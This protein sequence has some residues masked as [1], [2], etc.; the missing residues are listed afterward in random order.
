[1]RNPSLLQHSSLHHPRFDSGKPITEAPTGWNSSQRVRPGVQRL[2]D[3]FRQRGY[4]CAPLDPLGHAPV[5]DEVLL[6]PQRFGLSPTEAVTEDG[7][8]LLGVKTV[9]E[10]TTTLRAIYCGNLT[11][12]ASAVRD[13]ARLAWLHAEMEAPVSVD[14]LPAAMTGTGL[15][16]RLVHVQTWEH[17]VARRFPHAKRFSL[18]GCEA[19][20]PLL[21]VLV[22]QAGAHGVSKLVLGMPHRGRINVLVNLMGRPALDL[23]TYFDAKYPHPE[24]HKDLPYH[25]GARHRVSTRHGDIDLELAANPSHLQS[26]QPVVVGMARASQDRGA[27]HAPEQTLPVVMHGDA[28]LAGQG[29]V[30]ESLVMGRKHGYSVGGTVHIVINNQVGFTELNVMDAE[31]PRYATDVSRLIDAPVLRVSADAPEQVQR[32]AEIALAYRTRFGSDVFIDLIGYRRHGHSEHDV[33]TLTAPTRQ[34]RIDQLS[35]VVERY[36]A[37]LCDAGR[38]SELDLMRV[39]AHSRE[40]AIAAFDRP[41]AEAP[42]LGMP[43]AAMPDLPLPELAQL[44]GIV[45]TLTQLPDGFQ[46]HAMVQGLIKDW[47]TMS[48][49]AD[50]RCDWRFAENMA[51]ATLLQA[52]IGVRVSGMDVRRGTFMHRFAVWHGQQT[53]GRGPA[54]IQPLDR[55]RNG[56]AR[57]EIYN[58]QLSEEAVVGFEYGY[59]LDASNRLAIWE[60]QFGDFV[61]GAQ[62]YIDHYI[63]AGEAKWGCASGLT[64]LLPHGYEGVGPEHSSGFLGR[65]LQLC[66]QDNLQVAMPSTAAQ[67]F[68]LLRRQAC[69][70]PRRPLVVMSPKG[71]LYEEADS[72]TPLQQMLDGHFEPVLDDPFTQ[73]AAQ[74]ERVV[75]SSGKLHYDL[76]RGRHAASAQGIALLRLEQLYPFPQADLQ[77]LLKRYSGLRELVWAQEE[78]LNQGA[79]PFIRDELAAACPTGVPL[80]CAARPG[81]AAGPTV[82]QA[83]HQTEQQLLVMRALGLPSQ[84]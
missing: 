54:M 62:V 40:Q 11:L 63:A 80:R 10:L 41:P 38:A 78:E 67:W 2:L 64:L 27:S 35:T 21:D 25:L 20:L 47:R 71:K 69:L 44:Q 28:A 42:A 68:H 37:Q 22:E 49:Q 50:A 61:N 17:H 12:D 24:Q 30:M 46:P 83:I 77:R 23:L 33:P 32:A 8:P 82:S 52:G 79:W 59:S 73:S 57:F 39:V 65:F 53:D 34:A 14:A 4:Q 84:P 3:A 31:Q 58:S 75:L 74:V 81:T 5:A 56:Q 51:Y 55:L 1:M 36:A 76:A 43:F 6:T 45:S 66:A 29:V 26:V 7:S 70:Q 60:A 19:L 13:E 9:Q 18:E 15:L 72:H 48:A 16:A